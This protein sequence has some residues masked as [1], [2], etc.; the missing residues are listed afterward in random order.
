MITGQVG[1]WQLRKGQIETVPLGHV[2]TGQIKS[3]QVK[4]RQNR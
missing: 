3:G 2:K 1:V 4:S